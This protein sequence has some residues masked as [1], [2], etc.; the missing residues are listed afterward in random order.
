MVL[1]GGRPRATLSTFSPPQSSRPFSPSGRVR[2]AL[3]Q[4]GLR[5]PQTP[6]VEHDAAGSTRSFRIDGKRER[7]FEVEITFDT[8]P[9]RKAHRRHLVEAEAAEF[10]TPKAEIGEAELCGAHSY[11]EIAIQLL[12]IGNERSR[13]A[14]HNSS[15]PGG[16]EHRQKPVR[17]T[18]ERAPLD[19]RRSAG[20]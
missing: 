5:L 6:F 20:I 3:A 2:P 7:A 8:E 1:H 14:L 16:C 15:G 17:C 9:E 13:I 11:V 4:R 12:F 18:G 10:R 19:Q